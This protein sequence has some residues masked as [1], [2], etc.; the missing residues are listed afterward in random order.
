MRGIA[1]DADNCAQKESAQ[2][3]REEGLTDRIPLSASKGAVGLQWKGLPMCSIL[4]YDCRQAAAA[5]A[6]N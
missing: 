5:N 6:S 4:A 1:Y 3:K 2:Q